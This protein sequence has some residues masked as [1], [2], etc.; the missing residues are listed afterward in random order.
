M[1]T[2]CQD[3]RH[4]T[5]KKVSVEKSKPVSTFRANSPAAQVPHFW[6]DLM[7]RLILFASCVKPATN[8]QQFN[9]EVEREKR[10]MNT[11]LFL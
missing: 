5:G 4:A 1:F 10:E 6:K 7:L 11:G 9:K 2:S 3:T 8:I